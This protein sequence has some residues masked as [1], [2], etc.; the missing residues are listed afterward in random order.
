MG[1]GVLGCLSFLFLLEK[2]E[3]TTRTSS[4]R[5][6]QTPENAACPRRASK[7]HLLPFRP[8]VFLWILA[9]DVKET[10]QLERGPYHLKPSLGHKKTIFLSPAFRMLVSSRLALILPCFAEQRGSCRSLHHIWDHWHDECL[11]RSADA[12]KGR[13]RRLLARRAMVLPRWLTG[14]RVS[15]L[16]LH[17]AGCGYLR[18]APRVRRSDVQED[19]WAVFAES[20]LG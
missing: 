19:H 11:A 12:P 7:R 4:F 15:S 10:A 2:F 3:R 8:Q 1:T 16:R 17:S 5:A 9:V 20:S 6:H 18:R 13:A 14:A